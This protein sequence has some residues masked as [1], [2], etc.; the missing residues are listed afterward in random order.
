V[1]SFDA[2]VG[3]MY[4]APQEYA[5]ETLSTGASSSIPPPANLTC[6]APVFPKAKAPRVI[7]SIAPPNSTT[8]TFAQLRHP[9]KQQIDFTDL[10]PMF[11]WDNLH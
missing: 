5:T 7:F 9:C 2:I 10:T 8:Q 11:R 3:I 6:E 1:P 4:Y